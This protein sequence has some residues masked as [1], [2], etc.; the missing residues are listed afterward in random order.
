LT[1]AEIIK[2]ISR[3]I[4]EAV[5]QIQSKIPVHQKAIFDRVML[6]AKE[7][8]TDSKGNIRISTKNLRTIGSIRMEIERIV[9]SPEW[10]REVSEFAR[11]FDKVADLQHKYFRTIESKYSPTKLLDEIKKQ[12]VNYALQSLGEA[13]IGIGVTDKIQNILRQ[14][15]T[16]GGSYTELVNVLRESLTDTKAGVG[17]LDRYVKQITTDSLNQFSRQ[18]S[19]AISSD[20]KMDWY[21]Y[22][23]AII[24]TSRDFCKALVKKKY[25]HRSEIPQIINGNF[26]EFKQIKGKINEK[27]ELPEGMIAGTNSANFF[28]YAGGYQC[29]HQ[30]HPVSDLVVPVGLRAKFTAQ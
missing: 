13:G 30:I 10:K 7:L 26:T 5:G 6:L 21:M 22:V 11:A 23:G 20:L 25:F 1:Q 29:N 16:T 28:V 9:N 24:D 8:E 14:N 4:D 27:T 2:E 12:S 17:V 3:V 19:T 18:Y 15:I